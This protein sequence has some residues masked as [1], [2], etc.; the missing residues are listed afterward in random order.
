MANNRKILFLKLNNS[1]IKIIQR[2]DMF[3]ISLD[4][5]LLTNFIKLKNATKKVIDFGTNN[6]AIAIFLALKYQVKV[7][8]LEIQKEAIALAY[9]NIVLNNLQDK[10]TFVGEDI[11]LYAQNNQKNYDK[12]ADVIVCN[13]PFF[14]IESN[15]QIKLEPLK[16]AARHEIHIN[17]VSIV[18]SAAK[19]L[20]EKG[21]LYIIYPVQRVDELLVALKTHNFGIKRMQI[22]YPKINKPANL[23]LIEAIYQKN[24]KLIVEPPLICHN[25]DNSY[26]QEIAK[27]YNKN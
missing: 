22:V 9:E 11:K 24:T 23:V 1:L 18:D 17:L 16:V 20:K 3:C 21:K 26:N 15:A 25:Q 14:D 6:G 27:W 19:L 8:G 10:I 4:T 12:K 13:P 5:I 2:K 7:L